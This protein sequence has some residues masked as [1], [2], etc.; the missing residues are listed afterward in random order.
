MLA[1]ICLIL[2]GLMVDNV[3]EHLT[4][5]TGFVFGQSF[6]HRTKFTLFK[7]QRIIEYK[8]TEVTSTSRHCGGIT[9]GCTQ[10]PDRFGLY[11][12][13]NWEYKEQSSRLDMY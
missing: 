12:N 13:V 3:L 2:L 4:K 8:W 10:F 1:T 7:V 6:L 11:T 5:R 9:S